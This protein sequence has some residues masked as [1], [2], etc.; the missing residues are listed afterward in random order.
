MM[1]ML[2]GINLN[3]GGQCTFKG[4]LK[5]GGYPAGTEPFKSTQALKLEVLS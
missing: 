4:E 1:I 5:K 3:G 2:K